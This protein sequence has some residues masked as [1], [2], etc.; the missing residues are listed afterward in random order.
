MEFARKPSSVII[1][2]LIQQKIYFNETLFLTA[3]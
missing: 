1:K 3:L 2:K